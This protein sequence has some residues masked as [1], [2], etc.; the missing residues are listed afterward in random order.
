VLDEAMKGYYFQLY[1]TPFSCEYD[2]R[3]FIGE[4]I[5]KK[6]V[7]T[8]KTASNK[9]MKLVVKLYQTDP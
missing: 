8:K 5:C 1:P 3:S 2:F 4:A 6:A 7:W 9:F